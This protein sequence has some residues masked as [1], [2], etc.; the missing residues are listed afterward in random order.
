MQTAHGSIPNVTLNDGTAIPQ[1]G[2]GTLDVQ[3]D[4]EVTRANIDKTAEIVGLALRAGYRHIDTAQSYGTERGVGEAIAA[5]GIPRRELYVT[6]KLANGNH[7]PDDVRRSFDQTLEHLGLEQLDLFLIHWPLPT[8]YDVDYVSTWRAMTEL[9]IGGRLRTV[10]VSNFQ[11]AHLDRIITETGIAPAVNQIEVHPYFRNDAAR[12][13]STRHD[14]A[15]EAWSPLGHDGKLLAD[16]TLA[17]LAATRGK[18]SAQVILRWH[19]QHGHI[20]IPKSSRRERMEENLNVFDFEL[21]A[22]EIATI[23]ALEKGEGG[24]VGPNPDTFE[25]VP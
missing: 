6:S 11:P 16:E 4:R 14:V 3:P 19:I 18:S 1:L 23:D 10:G 17:K 21:S 12:T 24:R 13:A 8:L 15:V 7:R 22:E 9:V 20:V 5:S 2:F 25:R